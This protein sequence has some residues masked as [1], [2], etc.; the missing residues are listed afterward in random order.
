M[1]IFEQ[2]SRQK[3]RFDTAK[4][5]IATEDLWSLSLTSL[6]TIAKNVNRILKAETEESFIST[7]SKSNEE[8][9]LKLEILKF[10]IAWRIEESNATKRKAEKAAKLS[11]LKQL[12]STK[13]NENLSQMSL[14]DIEKLIAETEAEG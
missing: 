8:L 9:E 7:R 6:D 14:E 4:G 11:Q 5:Q 3:L 12:A 13:A 1:N 10:V 2:A